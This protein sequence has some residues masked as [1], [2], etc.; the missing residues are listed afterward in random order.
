MDGL[1]SSVATTGAGLSIAR[2]SG[3]IRLDQFAHGCLADLAQA[4]AYREL[5]RAQVRTTT[6]LTADAT[7]K[8]LDNLQEL[9]YRLLKKGIFVPP[10]VYPAVPKNKAR[11]RFSVI[12]LHSREQI[13]EAL[14][15]LVETMRELTAEYE[16]RP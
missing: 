6:A 14:D 10:A 3:P 12:S 1:E 16:T 11:L 4:L 8:I 15:G 9:L 2:P 7:A 5:N 13:L